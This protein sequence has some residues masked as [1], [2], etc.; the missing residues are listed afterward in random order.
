M[1][2]FETHHYQVFAGNGEHKGRDRCTQDSNEHGNG[3]VAVSTADQGFR[4][5]GSFQPFEGE[6]AHQVLRHRTTAHQT[7]P[8]GTWV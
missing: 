4:A 8:Q 3:E 2:I 7:I 6:K 1:R 5:A